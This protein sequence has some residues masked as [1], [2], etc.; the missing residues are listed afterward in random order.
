MYGLSACASV[1][2]KPERERDV[3]LASPRHPGEQDVLSLRDEAERRELDHKIAI[4]PGLEGEVERLER[5]AHRQPRLPHAALGAVLDAPAELRLEE[6]P[7]P[8]EPGLVLSGLGQRFVER[9]AQLAEAEDA[10]GV[11]ERLQQLIGV[12]L[13]RWVCHGALPPAG[14]RPPVAASRNSTAR[15]APPGDPSSPR[16]RG[17][18][19][20]RRSAPPA[21]GV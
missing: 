9:A 19:S 2:D 4:E 3:A 5:L 12:L 21:A 6:P 7:Q 20:R 13:R 17:R 10:E 14:N 15:A 1:R 11:V 8:G 18:A 16:G